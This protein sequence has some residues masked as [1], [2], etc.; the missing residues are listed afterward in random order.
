LQALIADAPRSSG[1]SPPVVFNLCA[2]YE[3]RSEASYER[4]RRLLCE[5]AQLAGDDMPAGCFKLG[6]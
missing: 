2:L 1:C 3:L 4:K 5:V 6:V